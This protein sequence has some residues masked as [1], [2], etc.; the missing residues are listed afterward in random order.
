MLKW[1][2]NTITGKSRLLRPETVKKM[3]PV[4]HEFKTYPNQGWKL[5]L[6]VGVSKE[7]IEVKSKT[8]A[9]AKKAAKTKTND[10]LIAD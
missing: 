10:D 5:D 9:A 6:S 4:T 7:A 1:H 3:P 8:T 2:T